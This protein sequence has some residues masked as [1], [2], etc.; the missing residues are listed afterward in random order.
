MSNERNPIEKIPGE[1]TPSKQ[2]SRYIEGEELRKR[3]VPKDLPNVPA[4]ML[5]DIPAAPAKGIMEKAREI[6]ERLLPVQQKQPAPPKNIIP[7]E[8]MEN[9]KPNKSEAPSENLGSLSPPQTPTVA[10]DKSKSSFIG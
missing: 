9:P 6:I 4:N 3:G 7:K 10:M 2:P 8:D 5:P 1:V